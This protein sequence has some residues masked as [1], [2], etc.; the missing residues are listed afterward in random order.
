MKTITLKKVAFFWIVLNSIA[1][2]S[3]KLKWNPSF[4]HKEGI[5]IVTNYILTPKYDP[6]T[7]TMFRTCIYNCPYAESENFYPFHEF[8]YGWGNSYEVNKGFLG[9]FGYYGY[10]EFIV[11]VI[12]PLLIYLLFLLYKILFKNN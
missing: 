11:Y 3:Y 9:I 2:L 7:Q 5:N 4:Q 1:F 10:D 8:S 6:Y 12:I